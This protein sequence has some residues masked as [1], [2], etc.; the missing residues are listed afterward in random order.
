MAHKVL[1]N[2]QIGEI[3]LCAVIMTDGFADQFG[4][5]YSQPSKVTALRVL[6]LLL[7]GV[8]AF[9]GWVSGNSLAITGL[10]VLSGLPAMIGLMEG[11]QPHRS[12]RVGGRTGEIETTAWVLTA[13]VASALTGGASSSLALLFVIAPAFALTLG[14]GRLAM[15]ASVFALI[16][17]LISSLLENMGF[18]EDLRDDIG[19]FSTWIAIAAL[20]Q[21]IA[22]FRIVGGVDHAQVNGDPVGSEAGT[23]ALLKDQ[24]QRLE[25]AEARAAIADKKLQDRS[26]FFAQ[27]SHELR[28]PLNAIIG[29]SEMMKMELF[30]PLPKR[31]AEYADLIHVGGNS[32]QLIVDDVLDLS[33]IE[34]GR[35][36]I[37]PEELD[38][39]S[40][41]A[42]VVRFMKDQA[43]R[44]NVSLVLDH[45]E[46]TIGHADARAFRQIALNLVSNAI[47]HS[48]QNSRV[49]VSVR[50]EN[51]VAILQVRD[52]GPGLDPAAFSRLVRPFEQAEDERRGTG[53]GLSVSQAFLGLHGGKLQLASRG[54]KGGAVIEAVFPDPAI[55]L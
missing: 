44:A 3:R 6:W 20:I 40:A 7:S 10:T 5:T 21:L 41:S 9:I 47:K 24:K 8:A 49:H 22:C 2:L 15:E 18:F 38:F 26:Q 33:K 29:F 43:Q 36:E 16:G 14:R 55:S 11:A 37:A 28:T 39:V 46:E 13:T 31:Y 17:Y 53:L 32:L 54:R 19:V 51:K 25:E 52:S 27:S 50:R 45:A 48:P 35:F 1:L 34:A 4:R 23:R 30:G 12:G 42:E